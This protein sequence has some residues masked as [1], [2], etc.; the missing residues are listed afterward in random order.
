[1]R[2][3]KVKVAIMASFAAKGNMNINTSHLKFRIF[4]L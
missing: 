4:D 2:G 1:M 3:R